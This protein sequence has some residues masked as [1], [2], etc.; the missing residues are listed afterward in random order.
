[1][2]P[3]ANDLIP[4]T[5]PIHLV[6]VL[7]W[8]I[9]LKACF[10]TFFRAYEGVTFLQ[11]GKIKIQFLGHRG[12]HEGEDGLWGE[13]CMKFP[14]ESLFPGESTAAT[15]AV[16]QKPGLRLELPPAARSL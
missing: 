2:G 15:W 5:I 10:L 9:Q 14:F 4:S 12:D 8:L 6:S 13:I 7:S 16:R 1:M 11:Q 3:G